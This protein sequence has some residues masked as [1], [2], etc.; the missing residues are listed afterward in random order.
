[1]SKT[2]LIVDDSHVVRKIARKII[3]DFGFECIDAEDGQVAMDECTKAMPD[4]VILDWNMPVMSGMEFLKNIRAMVGGDA[5]KIVFCTIEN[6]I[7]HITHAMEAGA[8]E[9]IMKPFSAE[10]IESKFRYI[11]LM[12]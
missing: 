3:E 9:Y 2:C 5:P 10:I 1:M 6:D 11:G 4:V 8:N 12:N 7:D